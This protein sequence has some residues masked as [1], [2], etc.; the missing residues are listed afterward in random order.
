MSD[1]RIC[2]AVSV[3]AVKG[4]AIYRC[5]WLQGLCLDAEKKQSS[6]LLCCS[7][8]LRVVVR[9][10]NTEEKCMNLCIIFICLFWRFNLMGVL[11]GDIV[12]TS[13]ALNF[14][15]LLVFHKLMYKYISVTCVRMCTSIFMCALMRECG[16][17]CVWSCAC[18]R[19]VQYAESCGWCVPS[20]QPDSGRLMKTHP[21]QE[22]KGE[23]VCVYI[24]L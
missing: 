11:T 14:E 17:K 8:S 15:R 3:V 18:V 1:C 16:R 5:V 13:Y 19:P 23:S 24:D 4:K 7:C 9:K 22:E 2:K 12:R 6:N 10:K 21:C 20:S